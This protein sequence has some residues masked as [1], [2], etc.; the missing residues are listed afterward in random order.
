MNEELKDRLKESATYAA[1]HIVM[2]DHLNLD[3]IR[4]VV[5][6]QTCHLVEELAAKLETM[7]RKGLDL[8]GQNGQLLIEAGELRRKLEAA[9]KDVVRAMGQN[10]KQDKAL[11]FIRQSSLKWRG[12]IDSALIAGPDLIVNGEPVNVDEQTTK[13]KLAKAIHFIKECGKLIP[14][15]KGADVIRKVVAELEA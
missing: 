2:L 3:E 11:R 6:D 7:T 1:E 8:C 14:E 9:E 13:A 5:V 4:R 10:R 12:L 15:H